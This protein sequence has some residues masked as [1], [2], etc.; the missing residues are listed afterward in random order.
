MTQPTALI[1][2]DSEEMRLL[3]SKTLE[4]LGF[5]IVSNVDNG[6][7]ALK[8]I[9][10]VQPKICFLDIDMPGKTGLQILDELPNIRSTV[11]AVIISGHSTAENVKT[12]VSKGA[13]GF[14]VKPYSFE[15]IRQITESFFKTRVA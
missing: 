7:D 13:K 8:C 12:A 15:K 10:E 3:L 2:D 4:T 14:V 1:A 5:S 9:D 11:Y 6:I